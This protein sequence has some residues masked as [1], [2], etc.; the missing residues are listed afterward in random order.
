MDIA[1]AVL[2]L[3]GVAIAVV[4]KTSD[5]FA[6]ALVLLGAALA[7]GAGLLSTGRLSPDASEDV[8]LG[9]LVVGLP[10][11]ALLMIDV[12]RGVQRDYT[13]ELRAAVDRVLA[14][15]SFADGGIVQGAS[16]SGEYRG[17]PVSVLMSTGSLDGL[18]SPQ[19]EVR[20][21]LDAVAGEP[22]TVG[23]R[24]LQT[25]H[26][27]YDP[28]DVF[29]VHAGNSD[30]K[31]RLREAGV[32]DLISNHVS[33]SR[34]SMAK[35]VSHPTVCR[36]VSGNDAVLKYQLAVKGDFPKQFTPEQFE[37]QL[38]LLLELARIDR[39]VNSG[40]LGKR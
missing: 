38:G 3:A 26:S 5:W 28:S 18:C 36:R 23:C 34:A 40:Q 39:D 24:C 13:I 21:A 22:W 16:L 29:R 15:T 31:D 33:G 32:I 9:M 12:Q 10:A 37:A 25:K 20:V 27:D 8:R 19:Y 4:R 30:L 11:F 1:V 35:G 7:V 14:C 17:I 6:R 2:V